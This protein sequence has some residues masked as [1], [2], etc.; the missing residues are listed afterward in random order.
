M[1]KHE[2][3]ELWVCDFCKREFADGEQGYEIGRIRWDA[4]HKLFDPVRVGLEYDQ[5]LP[6]IRRVIRFHEE[7][8]QEIAGESFKV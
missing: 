4:E 3:L 1:P 8:F 5:S 7:C 6:S 2:R